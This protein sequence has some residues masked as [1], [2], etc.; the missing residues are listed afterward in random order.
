M[1]KK[2]IIPKINT[3]HFGG[4]WIG[5]G[6]L[7]GGIIP[8]II[9]LLFHIFLW[10][11]CI[12]GGIILVGF[13]IVFA[14]EIHQDFGKTPYYE[15]H[16]NET[17]PFDPQKQYAVI[18][19]SVCSGEKVAG[20]RNIEDGIFTEVMLI[21]TVEDEKRFKKIYNLEIIKKSINFLCSGVST[22]KRA[23]FV[24]ALSLAI[25]GAH[26]ERN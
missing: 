10:E 5:I 11:L 16:L 17:I 3:I 8:F 12:I 4:K 18:R 24:R 7:T 9:W 26:A 13:I 20:F 6:V 22:R 21:R 23:H 25:A 19:S 15:R 14:I 1:M 2:P